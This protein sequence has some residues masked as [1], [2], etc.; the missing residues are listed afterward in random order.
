MTELV[1]GMIK[2]ADRVDSHMK[3]LREKNGL[4]AE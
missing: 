3:I 2:N 1:N 4:P